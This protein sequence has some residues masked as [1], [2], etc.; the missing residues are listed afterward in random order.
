MMF[1]VLFLSLCSKCWSSTT[2]SSR[3]FCSK[4]V[5]I[6]YSPVIVTFHAVW[7]ETLRAVWSN[8][9]PPKRKCI[10][11]KFGLKL[12]LKFPSNTSKIDQESPVTKYAE[13]LS[14]R[15]ILI[16]IEYS[17]HSRKMT[18]LLMNIAHGS[19]LV[20]V[21]LQELAALTIKFVLRFL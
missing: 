5:S 18:D 1:F 8:S 20:R 21:C 15:Q 6:Y 10:K 17:T 13:I 3:M 12:S 7:P 19:A 2:I 16:H 14:E 11:I 4:S 9:P